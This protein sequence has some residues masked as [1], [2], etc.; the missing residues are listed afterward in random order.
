MMSEDM[1]Q[2]EQRLRRQPVKKVP[3]DWR[4]DILRAAQVVQPREEAAASEPLRRSSNWYSI[5]GRELMLSLWPN[6]KVWAGLAAVW[7]LIAA[8]NL[9]TRD[10]SPAPT[11]AEKP[12]PATPERIAELKQ[13]QRM[14][15]EL[16]GLNEMPDADR[17][18]N[19]PLPP[20]SQ[21]AG[22]VTI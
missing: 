14:F 10:S 4:A 1:D 8:L 9:S 7:V 11:L 21:R 18:R 15:A 12:L 6:S 3:A 20:H 22:C 13:Q 2:F 17:P 19:L 16:A 5:I